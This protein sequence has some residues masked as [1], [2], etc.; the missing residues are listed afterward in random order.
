MVRNWHR[1]TGRALGLAL[2]LGALACTTQGTG[3]SSDT[4]TCTALDMSEQY[5]Q[6]YGTTRQQAYEEA[7]QKCRLNAPDGTTCHAAEKECMPPRGEG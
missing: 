5:F 3:F 1:R 6:G 4:W 7:M 2:G